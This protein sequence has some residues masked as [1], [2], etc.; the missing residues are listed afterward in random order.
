[1]VG[2]STAVTPAPRVRDAR[3]GCGEKLMGIRRPD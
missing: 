2:P 1:L 3:L